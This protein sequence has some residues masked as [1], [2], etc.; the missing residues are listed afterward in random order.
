ERECEQ[1][2]ATRTFAA[3]LVRELERL[4]RRLECCSQLPGPQLEIGEPEQ[5]LLERP[6]VAGHPVLLHL[7]G[8]HRACRLA[9]SGGREGLRQ[10]GDERGIGDRVSALACPP[11]RGHCI[12]PSSCEPR[13]RE[14]DLHGQGV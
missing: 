5:L 13:C 4:A 11:Q 2:T 12:A 3:E 14:R 10:P 9:L 7:A 6:Y 8:K 1:A